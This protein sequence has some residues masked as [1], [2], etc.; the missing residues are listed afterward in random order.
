MH[1]N[2]L[3][4]LQRWLGWVWVLSLKPTLFRLTISGHEQRNPTNQPTNQRARPATALQRL[5][6]SYGY[7][8]EHSLLEVDSPRGEG[9]ALEKGK[10]RRAKSVGRCNTRGEL[11]LGEGGSSCPSSTTHGKHRFVRTIALE[12]VRWPVVCVLRP[13][14]SGEGTVSEPCSRTSSPLSDLHLRS[15]SISTSIDF[16]SLAE[17]INAW[18]FA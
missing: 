3:Q 5:R 14:T 13:V 18:T 7:G 2:V 15:T 12:K 8:R 17:K 1:R 11:H 6:Y 10:G 9:V 16:N 4:A